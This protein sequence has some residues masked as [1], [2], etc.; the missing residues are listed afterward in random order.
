MEKTDVEHGTLGWDE[1]KGKRRNMLK[2]EGHLRN[3][4]TAE[5]PEDSFSCK[6][7]AR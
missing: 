3:E 4:A 6:P 1:Q 2:N 7:T 5:R